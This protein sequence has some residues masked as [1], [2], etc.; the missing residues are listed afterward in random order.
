MGGRAGGIDKRSGRQNGEKKNNESGEERDPRG[1]G[2]ALER[3]LAPIKRHDSGEKKRKPK[4]TR[5]LTLNGSKKQGREQKT[6]EEGETIGK[7]VENVVLRRKDKQRIQKHVPLKRGGDR[8][9][10]IPLS[11]PGTGGGVGA[12]RRL[13]ADEER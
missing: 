13:A 8:R 3:N 11:T 7:T 5:R 12:A 10:G 2:G 9:A 1:G 4:R 6:K